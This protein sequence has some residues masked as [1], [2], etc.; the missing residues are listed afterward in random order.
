MKLSTVLG[1]IVPELVLAVTPDPVEP[2]L[3]TIDSNTDYIVLLRDLS[4]SVWGI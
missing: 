1:P 2:Q 4:D 3:G